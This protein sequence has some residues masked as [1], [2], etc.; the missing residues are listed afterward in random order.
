[1]LKFL[2]ERDYAVCLTQSEVQAAGR[3]LITLL[4]ISLVW[5]RHRAHKL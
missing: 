3:Q 5:M 2:C 1:M 4:A